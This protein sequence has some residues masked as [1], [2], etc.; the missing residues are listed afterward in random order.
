MAT[1][2]KIEIKLTEE[3]VE[4]VQHGTAGLWGVQYPADVPGGVRRQ[5]YVVKID[6]E[7]RRDDLI[8]A[9]KDD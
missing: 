3:N 1:P 4:L 9:G 2:K 5:W 7:T 8:K 6:A